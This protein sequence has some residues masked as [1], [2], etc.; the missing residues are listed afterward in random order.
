MLCIKVLL[1]LRESRRKAPC[2]EDLFNK[3]CNLQSKTYNV[4]KKEAL[5]QV[6]S[7]KLCEFFMW[8]VILNNTCKRLLLD[9]IISWILNCRN[10]YLFY[11]Q[12][13]YVW[14]CSGGAEKLL[15]IF[16]I[17]FRSQFWWIVNLFDVNL[18]NYSLFFL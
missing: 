18:L 5:A 6:F 12:S 2:P 7:C 13:K 15:D 14:F 16:K 4:I 3:A 8:T 10:I 9:I 17:T 1:K 11:R